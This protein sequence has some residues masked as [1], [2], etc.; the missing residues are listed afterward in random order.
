[1]LAVH[2]WLGRTARATSTG[3]AESEV[4][5]VA[6]PADGGAAYEQADAVEASPEGSDRTASPP[7]AFGETSHV[8][9]NTTGFA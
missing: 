3:D 9:V 2:A 8:Y 4:A 6:A 5:R 1:M 7:N